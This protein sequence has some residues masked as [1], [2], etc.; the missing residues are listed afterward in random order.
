MQGV[1]RLKCPGLA[2]LLDFEQLRVDRSRRV[3]DTLEERE[4]D[5]LVQVPWRE[6][7][8]AA[9]HPT[10]LH[11]LTEH[12]SGPE[13]NLSYRIA[14][15]RQA[16]WDRTYHAWNQGQAPSP[17]RLPIVVP[18]LVY[19]GAQ[20][21]RP[22][23]LW[24]LMDGPQYWARQF[25]PANPLLVLSLPEES[26]DHLRQAGPMG[27]LLALLQAAYADADTF[28]RVWRETATQFAVA[29]TEQW[30]LWR[31]Q[32]LFM[33]YLLSHYRPTAE[34][35]PLAEYLAQTI[36]QPE[37]HEEVIT[38]NKTL[39]PN[40]YELGQLRALQRVVLLQGRP[41]SSSLCCACWRLRIGRT[42]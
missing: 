20:A 38:M 16:I 29:P 11:I 30:P 5:L 1:V 6:P 13:R 34:Q 3:A 17:L 33:L 2:E 24:E 8:L 41:S 27:W 19:T 31:K 25:T 12:Q 37:L 40:I 28:A 36:V 39:G 21:W 15:H 35:Q 18:L 9:R 23:G 42:W 22:P 10:W 26:P 4:A 14:Y 7:E 32:I